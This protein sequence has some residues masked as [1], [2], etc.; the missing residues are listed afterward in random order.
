MIRAVL[1]RLWGRRPAQSSV[2]PGGAHRAQDNLDRDLVAIASIQ[3]SLLPA[4][5]PKI[6]TMELAVY[7][8]ASQEAGGD[9]YDI[10]RLSDGR[11]GML[12]AD[13]SGHGAPAAVLMAITHAIA[14]LYPGPPTVPS[15]M[16]EFLNRH[17]AARYTAASG[18]FVTAFYGTYDPKT[19]ELLYSLAGHPPPRLKHCDNGRLIPLVGEAGPPLGV[20]MD[21][22]YVD[23]WIPLRPGDQLVFYTD[24]ITETRNDRGEL[25]GARRLDR[26]LDCHLDAD[27]LIATVLQA[28]ERFTEGGPIE[29]DRTLL[30]AKVS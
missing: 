24:G 27:A 22:G 12:I 1:D 29:D 17:L 2:L 6:P 15:K 18:S 13:V 10:F 23:A 3:Q 28:L 21:Q 5:L 4:T 14:H 8:R 11:W 19:R 26:L 30:I 20:F 16:L 7:Y 25:F 9:Y